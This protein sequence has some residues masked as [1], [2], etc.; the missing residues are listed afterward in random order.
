MDASDVDTMKRYFT[1]SKL[2]VYDASAFVECED[3]SIWGTMSKSCSINFDKTI[4]S[5]PI[6]TYTL[7]VQE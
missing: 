3:K 6:R 5:K 4:E 7:K 2:E 1:A